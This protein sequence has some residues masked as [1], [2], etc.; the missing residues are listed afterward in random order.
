LEKKAE[1]ESQL[2]PESEVESEVESESES[3]QGSEPVS[4]P[5]PA[6][7]EIPH[8]QLTRAQ[9]RTFKR[10]K[11]SAT[12]FIGVEVRQKMS[13]SAKKQMQELDDCCLD[14]CIQL[15]DHRLTG[16][17]YDSAIIGA[18]AIYGIKEGGGWLEAFP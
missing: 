15:L 14:F 18:L 1:S 11:E 5:E 4:R 3:E 16:N 10:L 9:E 8:Y 12:G 2:R 17:P 13:K 6:K 7:Q